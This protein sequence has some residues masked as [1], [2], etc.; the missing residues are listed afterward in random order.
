VLVADPP[1]LILP[2]AATAPMSLAMS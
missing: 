1:V 2:G